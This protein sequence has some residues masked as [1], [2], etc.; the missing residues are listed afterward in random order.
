MTNVI[1]FPRTQPMGCAKCLNGEF[2]I[3]K[4]NLT[5]QQLVFCPECGFING[6]LVPLTE[7]LDD[8]IR[9][10]DDNDND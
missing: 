1:H 9:G 10:N 8:M 7:K 5:G 3:G 6:Q 2:Y 4:H